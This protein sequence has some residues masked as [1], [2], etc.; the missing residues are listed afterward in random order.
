MHASQLL[1]MLASA[2]AA[3]VEGYVDTQRRSTAVLRHLLYAYNRGLFYPC[4]LLILVVV[5]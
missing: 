3:Y 2:F 4:P 5:P 1:L